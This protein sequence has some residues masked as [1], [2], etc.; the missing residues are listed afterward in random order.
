MFELSGLHLLQRQTDSLV[1]R[2]KVAYNPCLED[3]MPKEELIAPS[4]RKE[5]TLSDYAEDRTFSVYTF[6][7]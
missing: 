6:Y 3:L 1:L 4:K 7:N 5:S 2:A